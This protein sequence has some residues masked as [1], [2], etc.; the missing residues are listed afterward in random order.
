M[1]ELTTPQKCV[2]IRSGVEIWI[3]ARKA[4]VLIAEIQKREQKGNRGTFTYEG[5]LINTADLVGVF[6]PQDMENATRRR[7][8]QWPCKEGEWHAKGAECDCTPRKTKERHEQ[9]S[10]AIKACGKCTAGFVT[11]DDG[12]VG[13]CECI[14]PFAD[15]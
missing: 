6:L 4:D 1:N 5:R 3:D 12:S 2:Q 15:V 14:T 13:K 9:I 10:A 7:N 8:G 11:L